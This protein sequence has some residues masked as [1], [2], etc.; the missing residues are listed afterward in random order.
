MKKSPRKIKY[1]SNRDAL[2]VLNPKACYIAE[3]LFD[4]H[5]FTDKDLKE[6]YEME[7]FPEIKLERKK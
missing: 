4:K 1:P 6:F 7:P 2:R 5:I 3:V